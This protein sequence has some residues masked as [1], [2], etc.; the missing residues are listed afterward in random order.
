VLS[1]QALLA[2]LEQ[3]LPLL[4]GT[5]RDAPERQRTLRAT[6]AWSYDLLAPGEQDLFRRL[7]IFRGG[8]TLEA[9]EA[10][11]DAD[12]DTLASLVDKSLLRQRDDRFTMLETI[13]E[14][15]AERL[16]E[17]GEDDQI[18]HRHWDYFLALAKEAEL[19]LRADPRDWADRL[20]RKP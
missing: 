13:R 20:E 10:V 19:P 16:A 7:A 5:A 4:A 9:A 8:C 14:F 18:R 17:S 11:C 6:I 2:R 15:A 1:T 3:R 12:L